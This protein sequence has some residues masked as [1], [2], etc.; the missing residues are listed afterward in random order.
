MWGINYILCASFKA[1]TLEA[2][3]AALK[4]VD[5]HH[6]ISSNSELML[7][8]FVILQIHAA[9]WP[10]WS[11][12]PELRQLPEKKARHAWAEEAALSIRWEESHEIHVEI[13]HMKHFVLF[14]NNVIIYIGLESLSHVWWHWTS[15]A[16]A[17]VE[18]FLSCRK[19]SSDLWRVH[20]PICF[21][22][23]CVCC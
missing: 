22:P 23:L 18:T 9:R 5:G 2:G 15:F 14:K 6:R 16:N 7:S 3:E 17:L 1:S 8:S 20:Q 10:S 13:T 12:R 21:S 19:L 11:S 4:N